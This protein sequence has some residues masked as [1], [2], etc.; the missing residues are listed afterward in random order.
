MGSLSPERELGNIPKARN[1]YL[2]NGL[3]GNLQTV[4]V[5]K[6]LAESAAGS[7]LVQRLARRIV[8]DAGVPSH[9]Y[10]D[11]ALAIGEYVKEKVRYSRDPEGYEQLQAPDLLINDIQAGLAQGDCDDM[12]LLV[13]SLLLSIGHQPFFRMVRYEAGDGP[14]AHIYVVDYEANQSGNKERIVLDCILKDQPIG[15]EVD[16]VSGDETPA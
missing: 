1:S 13:A 12:A 15:T 6:K 4:A 11:E 10:A 16:H 3:Q 5:M 8:L 9:Y 2:S 7:P 14:Y